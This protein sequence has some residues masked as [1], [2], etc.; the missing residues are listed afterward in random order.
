M[1]VVAFGA[2]YFVPPSDPE[3]YTRNGHAVTSALLDEGRTLLIL[4]NRGCNVVAYRRDGKKVWVQDRIAADGI[5]LKSCTDGII[6]AEIEY[7]YEGSWRTI[8]IIAANGAD[9]V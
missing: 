4:A 3:H 5:Q 7:D 1:V 2:C 8:R 6:T 9:A